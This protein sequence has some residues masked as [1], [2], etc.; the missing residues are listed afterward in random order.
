MAAPPPL[1][2]ATTAAAVHSSLKCGKKGEKFEDVQKKK[3]KLNLNFLEY[4]L[5][6]GTKNNFKK[7]VD[8]TISSTLSYSITIEQFWMHPYSMCALYHFDEH[9]CIKNYAR[10]LKQYN[11]V[12]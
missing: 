4:R 5:G 9:M 10:L 12:Y 2:N 11:K 1:K 7:N 6:L 3:Q 8:Y